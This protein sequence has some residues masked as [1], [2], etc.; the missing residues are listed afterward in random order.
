MERGLLTLTR[1][2]GERVVIQVDGY[3]PVFVSIR[4][5]NSKNFL[6]TFDSPK[7]IRVDREEVYLQR[8]ISDQ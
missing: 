2:I 3:P 4:E 1:K 5:K 6:M 8:V 7:S